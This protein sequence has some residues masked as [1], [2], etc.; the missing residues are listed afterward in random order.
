MVLIMF[1]DLDRLISPYK[2]WLSIE[3][4]FNSFSE[5]FPYPFDFFNFIGSARL[6]SIPSLCNNDIFWLSTGCDTS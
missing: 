2:Y 3:F 1:H 4:L 6:F 5:V